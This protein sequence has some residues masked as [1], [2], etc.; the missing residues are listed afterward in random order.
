VGRRFRGLTP[1]AQDRAG[2]RPARGCGGL[3]TSPGSVRASRG[4]ILTIVHVTF[5]L[6]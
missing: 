6:D 1:A 5:Q 4:S 3:W 2:S